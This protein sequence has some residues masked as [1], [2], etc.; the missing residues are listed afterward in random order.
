[1]IQ[2]TLEDNTVNSYIP[3][4]AK[5][6]I[7][8]FQ[9]KEESFHAQSH[10]WNYDGIHNVNGTSTSY[11][12]ENAAITAASVIPVNGPVAPTDYIGVVNFDVPYILQDKYV[13][14]NMINTVT[15]DILTIAGTNIESLMTSLYPTTDTN[16]KAISIFNGLQVLRIPANVFN[17]LTVSPVVKNYGVYYLKVSSKYIQTTIQSFIGRDQE[18]WSAV[19]PTAPNGFRR[20]ITQVDSSPFIADTLWLFNTPP[21][22]GSSNLQRG[23]LQGSVVEIWNSTQTTLKQVKF[24]VADDGVNSSPLLYLELSPDT[25][26][27][28]S[29]LQVATIGDVLRIFPRE[30]YF[31]PIFIQLTYQNNSTDIMSLVQFMSNDVCRDL[32]SG[33]F[34]IYDNNGITIDS[35]GNING[36]VIMSYQIEQVGTKEIRKR[37]TI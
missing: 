5:K 32:L 25:V 6:P 18:P 12:D 16:P 35:S 10:D 23:R 2:F 14:F 20:T 7:F 13:D 26:G 3:I 36:N 8:G 34:E 28:D 15:N 4:T 22:G 27:Y 29:P 1:M 11:G 24:V 31:K 37:L 19:D 21:P 17:N 33:I 30:T 9:V